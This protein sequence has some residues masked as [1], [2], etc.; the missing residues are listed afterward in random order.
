MT[1]LR[2]L[3]QQLGAVHRGPI[4]SGEVLSGPDTIAV[5]DPATEDVIT[6]I[7]A[8]DVDTAPAAVGAA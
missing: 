8:G 7:A 6:E 1:Y 5:V 4:V 3:E 2:D